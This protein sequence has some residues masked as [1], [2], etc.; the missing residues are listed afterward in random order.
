MK[1]SFKLEQVC[2]MLC[3]GSL[4]ICIKAFALQS[5]G[6]GLCTGATRLNKM[7]CEIKDCHL[8]EEMHLLVFPLPTFTQS[9]IVQIAVG[10]F[11]K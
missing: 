10:L 9:Y 1:I 8:R 11:V 3:P 2:D 4:Q 7:T 5:R 6:N